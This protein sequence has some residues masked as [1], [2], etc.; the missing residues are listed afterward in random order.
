MPWQFHAA[1]SSVAN[2]EIRGSVTR[3][4]CIRDG[5]GLKLYTKAFVNLN[6]NAEEE[7]YGKQNMNSSSC[8]LNCPGL[9]SAELNYSLF[10][11]VTGAVTFSPRASGKDENRKE[12]RL[13]LLLIS[14]LFA[15][16]CL[17][18]PGQVTKGYEW[19]VEVQSRSLW[20]LASTNNPA[21]QFRP[22]GVL[23]TFELSS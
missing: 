6:L 2:N 20:D 22:F 12:V 1:D 17:R 18:M 19:F 23:V 3:Y 11:V 9:K 16:W 13:D 4:W 5:E 21:A 14:G 10:T 7:K 8:T 15:D